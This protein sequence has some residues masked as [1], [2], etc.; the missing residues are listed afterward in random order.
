MSNR[1]SRK[2][3]RLPPGYRWEGLTYGSLFVLKK[4]KPVL[5]INYPHM[6]Y[7][8]IRPDLPHEQDNPIKC[9]N[10]QQALNLAAALVALGEVDE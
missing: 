1:N 10:R 7:R 5:C 4:G 2:R 9:D 3:P 8:L 6:V